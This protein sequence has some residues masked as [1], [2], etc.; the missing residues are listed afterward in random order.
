MQSNVRR[1]AQ[2]V[3]F[4]LLALLTSSCKEEPT[5]KR[6]NVSP[7]L[8]CTGDTVHI[9]WHIKG[10]DRLEVRTATGERLFRTNAKKGVWDSPP[11]QPS[12]GDLVLTGCSG[13]KCESRFQD[14]I[15]VDNPKWTCGYFVREGEYAADLQSC[16]STMPDGEF[17]IEGGQPSVDYANP[18]PS[19]SAEGQY[20]VFR[21]V[22]GYR[23]KIPRPHFSARARVVQ[24]KFDN[25]QGFLVDDL[26]QH[27]DPAGMF[28]EAVG[29]N[30]VLKTWVPTDQ[31]LAIA[32]PFHPSDSTWHLWYPQVAKIMIGAQYGTPNAGEKPNWTMLPID[33]YPRIVF[34]V[35]CDSQQQ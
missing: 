8:V 35:R 17:H 3:S 27:T 26:N 12:W 5:I 31:T 23:Y 20:P 32:A 21:S 25:I 22:E 24:V 18:L 4:L 1:F 6:L 7:Q 33:Q 29:A 13:G 34:Q 14:I 30:S 16:G 2:V 9:D 10:V 19:Q 11:Y 28:I 15:L